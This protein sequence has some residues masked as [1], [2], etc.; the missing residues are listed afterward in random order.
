MAIFVDTSALYA[1][2]SKQDECHEPARRQWESVL[3]GD[4]VL[5]TTNYVLVETY[6]LMGRRLGL[7][8]ARDFGR[9]FVPALEVHWV[10][11][12]M[13]ERATAALLLANRRDLSLVDCTSFEAMRDR[14]LSVAFAFDDHFSEWGYRCLPEGTQMG[15]RA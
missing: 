4:E 9:V 11:A 13:H 2:L 14:G 10:D 1:A 6:A 7:E 5:V 8:A 3:A 12:G 15:G